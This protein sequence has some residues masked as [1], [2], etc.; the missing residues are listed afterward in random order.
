[1]QK[2]KDETSEKLAIIEQNESVKEQMKVTEARLS[3][4]LNKVQS[5]EDA[6]SLQIGLFKNIV[7]C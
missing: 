5:D 6:R 3:F 1:M 4:L 2:S 7:I